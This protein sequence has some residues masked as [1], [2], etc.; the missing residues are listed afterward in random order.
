MGDVL[1]SVFNGFEYIPHFLYSINT[2]VLALASKARKNRSTCASVSLSSPSSYIE[3]PHFIWDK[4]TSRD[5]NKVV[6]F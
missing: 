6:A 1:S 2:Q 5:Y 3:P 4:W